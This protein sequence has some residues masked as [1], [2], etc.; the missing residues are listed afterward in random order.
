M[1]LDVTFWRNL[2]VLIA[3]MVVLCLIS[4][5]LLLAAVLIAGLALIAIVYLVNRVA[6]GG[7]GFCGS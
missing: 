6:D 7:S 3:A 1:R 2:A 4:P 5:W